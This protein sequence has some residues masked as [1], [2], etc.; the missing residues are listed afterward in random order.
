[1]HKLR[2]REAAN[3]LIIVSGRTFMTCFKGVKSA[4]CYP[5]IKVSFLSMIINFFF[6]FN[7]FKS[8]DA[9]LTPPL[10]K[11]PKNPHIN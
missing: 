8:L 5:N 3:I 7:T 2:E 11:C 6:Y 4:T 10:T 9:N 1:M